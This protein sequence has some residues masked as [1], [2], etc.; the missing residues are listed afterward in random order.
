MTTT[1]WEYKNKEV[2]SLEDL[3]ED[4][5]GF[6]YLITNLTKNKIYYGRKTVRKIGAKKK[7][8]KKEKQ[9]TE[10]KRKTY[11]YVNVEYKGWQEY[12]GSCIPLLE[13]IAKGD[14]IKKEIV[15]VCFSKS[16]LTYY[17]MKAIFCSECLEI[18]SCYNG[19]I[20]GRIFPPKV[21]D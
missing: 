10:N 7:L 13:D 8:T 14:K 15:R 20:G 18:D 11:K 9:L 6:I 12:N 21:K 4:C 2:N 3:P 19:N 16:E 5:V 1:K 17:E